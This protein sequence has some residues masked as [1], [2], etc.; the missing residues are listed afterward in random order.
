M[1]KITQAEFE[2]FPLDEYGRKQC[3]TGG[4]T[5]FKSFGERCVFGKG[6]KANSPFWSF[7]Y[8]PPFETEGKIYLPQTTKSYWEERLGLSLAGCYDEIGN[9]IKPLLPTILKRKDLTRCERRI[10]ESWL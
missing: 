6:C 8:E 3:P 5:A 9:G 10:L 2:D 4:Y 1:R 7:V